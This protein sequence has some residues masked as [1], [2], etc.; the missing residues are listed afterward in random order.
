MLITKEVTT[1]WN[2]T[3]RKY[4]EDLGYTY[5]KQHAEFIVKIEDLHKGS[6][7]KIDYQCDLCGEKASIMFYEYNEK[8][9]K[10]GKDLCLKCVH[11]NITQTTRKRNDD[12]YSRHDTHEKRKADLQNYLLE[13]K[14]LNKMTTNTFGKRLY[15]NFKSY[16]DDVYDTAI[17][18]GYKIEDISKTMPKNYYVNYPEILKDKLISFTTEYKRFPRIKEMEKILQ[19]NTHFISDFGGLDEFKKLINYDDSKDLIDL[20]GDHN[21][22]I[23][24][25][26]TANYFYSQGLKDKYN[27]EQYPFPKEDRY[28]RSDFTFYLENNK[29]LHVEV[30]GFRESENSTEKAIHYQKTRKFK[31]VLYE[32][33]SDDIILISINYE[34]FDKK[35]DEIQKHLYNLFSPYVNLKFKNVSYKKLL[36]PSLLTDDELFN[37]AMIVSPDGITLPMTSDLIKHSAGLYYQILKRGYTYGGFAKKFGVKT[38]QDKIEWSKKLIFEYFEEIIKVGKVINIK[39]MNEQHS[40][41]ADILKKYGYVTK[42]K[43]EYFSKINSIPEQE[44]KWIKNL[45]DKDINS[46]AK[47]SKKDIDK[48]KQILEKQKGASPTNEQ[49]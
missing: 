2:P 6:N 31:E 34:L 37:E 47:Y 9:N 28:F 46:T 4:Y 23:A 11:K 13:H 7:S 49:T 48:A 10:Y 25:L 41:L 14:T 8:K 17:E 36:S 44:L 43:I 22:S 33:Y 18:L 24:E 39:S 27:R 26:I 35:Y 5:T 21:R 15:D 40:N 20:R 38:K 3:T 42:L 12:N 1:T 30:W 16:K 32:K 45:I 29:E 19:I